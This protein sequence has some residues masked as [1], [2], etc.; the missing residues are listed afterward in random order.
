MKTLPLLLLLPTV[1]AAISCST[2]KET[3]M[4]A[5]SNQKDL[6]KE[7]VSHQTIDE[8]FLQSYPEKDSFIIVA[9]SP[10]FQ[11]N[12]EEKQYALAS[13]ARQI[14]I[15]Y[16]ARIRYQKFID[17]NIIGTLQIQKVDVSYNKNMALSILNKLTIIQ[18]IRGHDYYAASIRFKSNDITLYPVIETQEGQRP[19]WINNPPQRNG[20]LTGVGI[21]QRRKSVYESWE[22]ADKQAL[23]E[24]ASSIESTIQS[25]TATI[26][27][28][29]VG[30]SASTSLFRTLTE[31]DV[32][33]N[34]L[35]IIARWRE[36]DSSYYYSLA[37]TGKS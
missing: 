26:E 23:A 21:S 3:E 20:F 27:K 32:Y 13:A 12:M 22:E 19:S 37:I 11:D 34:G 10:R 9:V 17:E 1:L 8:L 28:S 14:S 35:Y 36:P 4:F 16:G 2:V 33:V 5:K 29:G 18:E 30:S 6:L 7:Q 24:I 25:G 15:Y 31:A